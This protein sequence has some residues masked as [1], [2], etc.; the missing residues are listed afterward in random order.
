LGEIFRFNNS[1]HTSAFDFGS[2]L[3][4]NKSYG[5]AR[6]WER[7]KIEFKARIDGSKRKERIE[8]EKREYIYKQ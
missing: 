6:T 8:R 7:F 5:V 1:Y 4:R 2:F 3:Y